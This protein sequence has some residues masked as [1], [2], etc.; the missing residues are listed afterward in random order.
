MWKNTGNCPVFKQQRET[1]LLQISHL[2][3]FL[4]NSSQYY[5]C[6]LEGKKRNRPQLIYLVWRLSQSLGGPIIPYYS[7]WLNSGY[8]LLIQLATN[9]CWEAPNHG[10]NNWPLQA[11][12]ETWSEIRGLALSWLFRYWGRFQCMEDPLSLRFIFSLKRQI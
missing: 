5:T 3:I 12:S 7:A 11:T 8:L 6:K 1:A 2:I 9:A 10:S 4:E